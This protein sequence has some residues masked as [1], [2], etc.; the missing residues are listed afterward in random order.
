M[1]N[2]QHDFYNWGKGNGK[3][4]ATSG[5]LGKGQEPLPYHYNKEVGHAGFPPPNMPIFRGLNDSK[6]D[7]V[8]KIILL[9]YR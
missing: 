1:D 7:K 2:G 3:G 8:Q 4:R 9:F 6:L 5:K